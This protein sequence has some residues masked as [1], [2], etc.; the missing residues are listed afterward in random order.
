MALMQR[1]TTL[2]YE[3][4]IK[5]HICCCISVTVQGLSLN[6]YNKNLDIIY[7][8]HFIKIMGPRGANRNMTLLHHR[9][10]PSN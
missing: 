6:T 10:I 7:Q 9:N 4:K 1:M 2:L 3:P 5:S 8:I